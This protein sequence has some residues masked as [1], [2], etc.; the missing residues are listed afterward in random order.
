[1]EE[2]KIP[3]CIFQWYVQVLPL[4]Y[5]RLYAPTPLSPGKCLQMTYLY[6]P[7]EEVRRLF[8]HH[9]PQYFLLGQQVHLV[10]SAPHN[11]Y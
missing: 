10:K 6:L 1:M 2:S 8:G 7:V 3:I 9:F 11:Q 4:P 5:I